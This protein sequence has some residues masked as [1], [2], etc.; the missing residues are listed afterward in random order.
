MTESINIRFGTE[1]LDLHEDFEIFKFPAGEVH[2]RLNTNYGFYQGVKLLARIQKSDDIIAL[3]LAIDTLIRLNISINDVIIPYFPYAR[4]DRVANMGESLSLK[5][6]A[7]LLI[8]NICLDNG[9]RINVL[10][11]HSDVLGALLPND[12]I[13]HDRKEVFIKTLGNKKIQEIKNDYHIICPDAGALKQ[14]YSIAKELETEK[15]YCCKKHR[16]TLTGEL[17]IAINYTDWSGKKCI[18]IDDI[19]D[20]GG[21]FIAI[22]KKLKDCGASEVL[23]YVTHGVFSKGLDCL[24]ENIDKIYTTNSYKEI[25]ETDFIKVLD[26]KELI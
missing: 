6:V 4:Q 11:P 9:L 21:T 19:C 5:V 17:T 3:L 23:L 24:K 14:T 10:D 2:V 13:V 22:A 8:N 25:D 1:I 26:I 16:D 15:I 18:I 12:S 20:G 7:E